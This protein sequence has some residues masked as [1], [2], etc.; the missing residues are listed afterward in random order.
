MA[1]A[2]V[3][4]K[5]LNHGLN[6]GLFLSLFKLFHC[7]IHWIVYVLTYLNFIFE[8]ESSFSTTQTAQSAQTH[9]SKGF[10]RIVW[11]TLYVYLCP[12]VNLSTKIWG[13]ETI[14]APL[15]PTV[16]DTVNTVPNNAPTLPR[17]IH[18]MIFTQYYKKCHIH[19]TNCQVRNLYIFGFCPLL[20]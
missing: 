3:C 4:S 13:A 8:F 20:L 1:H 2:C 9:E 14:L 18:W 15:L 19:H 5:M 16:L 7:H 12:W 6:H 10:I 11:S 17:N